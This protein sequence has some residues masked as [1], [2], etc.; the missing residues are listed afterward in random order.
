MLLHFQTDAEF[1]ETFPSLDE[2]RFKD[3]KAL[4]ECD[5]CFWCD[6]PEEQHRECYLC[7]V[8]Y[9][10]N[11][12]QKKRETE[13]GSG[14]HLC[15]ACLV[16]HITSQFNRNSDMSRIKCICGTG[17]LK[18]EI[19]E[20]NL[21]EKEY[22]RCKRIRLSRKIDMNPNAIWCPNTKCEKE[23]VK[24]GKSNKLECTYC[25]SFACFKC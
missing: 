5:K 17:E 4:H 6:L 23:V 16:S 15:H 11:D 8:C 9:I 22:E 21:T 10:K 18:E 1:N 13:C 20:A 3:K 7:Q 12:M 25:G 14:C 2:D 24:Q 19:F